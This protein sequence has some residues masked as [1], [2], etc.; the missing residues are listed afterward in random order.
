MA[1]FFLSR[2]W[3]LMKVV[4]VLFAV[5]FAF[6]I[7]AL[8]LF[9]LAQPDNYRT[10]LWQDGYFNRFNSNP[11]ARIY[12][13]VNKTPYKTPLVWS[14]FT[15]DFNV[16][17]SVLSMFI[18]IVKGVL[19]M[20]HVFWPVIG[21]LTHGLLVGLWAY[22]TFAQTHPDHSDPRYSKLS[23]PWYIVKS[24]NE[25]HSKSNIG[26]CK[27]AKA[28][29]GVT[30]IM[31][32]LFSVNTLLALWSMVPSKTERHARHA[33]LDSIDSQK[34]QMRFEP[35][36]TTPKQRHWSAR[37]SEMNISGAN[38][39][40]KN[41]A[42]LGSPTSTIGGMKTPTTPRTMAFSRLSGGGSQDLPLR[43]Q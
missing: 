9:A 3:R 40:S 33:S 43:N 28:S 14:Q 42:G 7:P 17:I 31:L 1:K 41:E 12:A 4:W 30:V 38:N 22:S 29:L 24:C 21:F 5:E 34:G 18:L 6:T 16:V 36:P 23:A 19:F 35:P 10:R 15:T 26:Y 25:A 8:A 11:T 37:A 32:F 13:M 2:R 39:A 27:Q 20:M